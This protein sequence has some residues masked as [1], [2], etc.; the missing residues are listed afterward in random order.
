[1]INL[2]A[3]SGLVES[4]ISDAFSKISSKLFAADNLFISDGDRG[5]FTGDFSEAQFIK[6]HRLIKRT[7]LR[8]SVMPLIIIIII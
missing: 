8:I 5:E 6:K 7:N 4:C 1:V 3:E 2:I